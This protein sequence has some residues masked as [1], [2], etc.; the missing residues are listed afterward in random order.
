MKNKFMTLCLLLLL[1]IGAVASTLPQKS[2][3]AF[4]I[5]MSCKEEKVCVLSKSASESWTNKALD[6]Q[7]RT[8]VQ[9]AL[10]IVHGTGSVGFEQYAN[11]AA[12]A[13]KVGTSGNGGIVFL[14]DNKERKARLEVSRDLEGVIPDIMAKRILV[15]FSEGLAQ[16]PKSSGVEHLERL[17]ID[18]FN[19]IDNQV[20]DS[21]KQNGKKVFVPEKDKTFT[22]FVI[23]CGI[24]VFVCSLIAVMWYSR[25]WAYVKG[26]TLGGILCVAATFIFPSLFV[27]LGLTFIIGFVVTFILAW[28]WHK[29][30]D[31]LGWDMIDTLPSGG[32]GNSVGTMASG[33]SDFAGGGATEGLSSAAEGLTSAMS[34]AADS[35]N[36]DACDLGGCDA[37]GCDIGG[38]DL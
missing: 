9:V 15:Q 17:L 31:S 6:L 25:G 10:L 33:V 19:Q 13:L 20:T 36:F 38:C 1:S 29:S 37:G 18:V 3:R 21:Y 14:M 32:S 16:A 35:C 2:D 24:I 23:I 34:G 22:Y 5:D 12:N 11:D 27:P 7:N 26:S 4:V 8:G 30:G 28:I